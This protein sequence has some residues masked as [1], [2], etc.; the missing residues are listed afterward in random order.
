MAGL[1]EV[2]IS[3]TMRNMG[4]TTTKDHIFTLSGYTNVVKETGTLT[5]G[6]SV[7]IGIGTMSA[8]IKGLYFRVISS[9]QNPSAAA[10]TVYSGV[11][12]FLSG[13]ASAGWNHLQDGDVVYLQPNDQNRLYHIYVKGTD[14]KEY[15]F[16]YAAFGI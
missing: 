12:L 5:S 10:S 8:G 2:S 11:Y 15:S 9:W 3:L 16:E 7:A 6:T 14:N 1:A 4:E 13:I